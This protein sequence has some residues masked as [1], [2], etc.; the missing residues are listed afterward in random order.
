MLHALGH[1]L[2]TSSIILPAGGS[3][4]TN[5]PNRTQQGGQ[6]HTTNWEEVAGSKMTLFPSLL[7]PRGGSREQDDSF[8]LLAPPQRR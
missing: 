4:L 2:G 5:T 7:L 6:T 3:Y 8:S 1:P